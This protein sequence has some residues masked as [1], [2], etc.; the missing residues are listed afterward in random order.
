[1]L[2]LMTMESAEIE[3]LFVSMD[4][5]IRNKLLAL[6]MRTP[7]LPVGMPKLLDIP[8]EGFCSCAFAGFAFR[9][10]LQPSLDIDTDAVLG[11]PINLVV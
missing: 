7:C 9:L 1:M 8:V 2:G 6:V 10:A 4:K 11:M 3:H 5:L